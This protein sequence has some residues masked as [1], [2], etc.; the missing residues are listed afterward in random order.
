MGK[1]LDMMN[2]EV[3]GKVIDKFEERFTEGLWVWFTD[4]SYVRVGSAMMFCSACDALLED[5]DVDYEYF[6]KEEGII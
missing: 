2:E 6:P 1:Y 3:Q 4:G 5:K